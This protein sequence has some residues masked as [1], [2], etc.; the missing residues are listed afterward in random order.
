MIDLGHH[1]AT[2][3]YIYQRHL[4]PYDEYVAQIYDS[5]ATLKMFENF[6]K[7]TAVMFENTAT[8]S[9]LNLN[10]MFTGHLKIYALF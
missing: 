5:R 4:V 1:T 3:N 10:K 8:K 7:N 9:Y 2:V 6:P